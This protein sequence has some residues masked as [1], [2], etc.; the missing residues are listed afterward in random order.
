M[1]PKKRWRSPI[2]RRAKL[3]RLS[4]EF[5]TTKGEMDYDKYLTN[6]KDLRGLS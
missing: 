4:V 6:T 2:S 3:R 5:S 1:P